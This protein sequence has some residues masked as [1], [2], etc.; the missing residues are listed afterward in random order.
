M[1]PEERQRAVLTAIAF[2]DRARYAELREPF[3]GPDYQSE[4]DHLEAAARVCLVYRLGEPPTGGHMSTEE[5]AGLGRFI[6]ELCQA[7]PGYR[8][9]SNFLETEGV[10]RG[11]RGERSLTGHIGGHRLQITYQFLI[12][13]LTATTP[14]IRGDFDT[15]IEQA[16]EHLLQRLLHG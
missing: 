16:R 12:H 9:P 5:R 4:F 8:P 7:G 14:E 1:T 11:L 6:A 15:V 3:T 2:G 10:I 13:Y